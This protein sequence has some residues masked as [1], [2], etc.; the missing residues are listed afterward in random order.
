MSA[1]KS[2]FFSKGGAKKS[3]PYF[4]AFLGILL[5]A[6]FY[7]NTLGNPFIWD[8]EGL[9][10]N[11][12][13][14][15]SGA[16]LSSVFLRDLYEQS[17]AGS[18]FYRP[19]Q[20]LSFMA[21][22][23]LWG[24]DP[25]GYHV[26]NILLQAAVSFLVFLLLLRLTG[27]WKIAYPAA[28]LFAVSPLH[29]EVVAYIA[30]RADMLMAVFA[31][32]SLLLFMRAEDAQGGWPRFA[33][34]AAS[35]VLFLCALLS[36]E[37]AAVLPLV[38]TGWVVYFHRERLR[39]RWYFTLA[40]FPYFVVASLYG[41][42]R[43]TALR[44]STLWLPELTKY[45]FWLRFMVLPR[46]IGEY[47]AMLLVPMGLHMSRTVTRPVTL[48]GMGVCLGA[49]ALLVVAVICA[50][51]YYRN[52][53]VGVFLGFWAAVFFLPQSGLFPINAFVAEHFIYLP[54]VSFY[55]LLAYLLFRSLGARAYYLVVA[56]LVLGYGLLTMSR[57]YEWKD[58][59][60]FYEG[61][62][63]H[64]P[65]SFLA[66]NN[67]GVAYVKLGRYDEAVERFQEA[68]ALKPGRVEANSNLADV[69]FRMGDYEK[70]LEY[71]R[72]VEKIVPAHKAA[73]IQNNIGIVYQ[74]Y[75]QT[76][77]ALERFQLALRLD[78]GLSYVH[79]NIAKIL[80]A[81]GRVEKAVDEIIRSFPE[82]D[83]LPASS[84]GYR[85]IIRT[86]LEEQRD[87]ACPGS[88]YNNL[89]AA[90]A[91]AGYAHWAYQSFLRALELRP[92][93]ADAFFNIGLLRARQGEVIAARRALRK[94]LDLS[95]EHT[96]AAR[97]M[98]TVR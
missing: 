76:E 85:P 77:K 67:L 3:L 88:F 50:L 65:A 31:L 98:D 61:I 27:D 18:N 23:R 22:H 69:H 60:L 96:R 42:L 92:D 51:V 55:A 46:V 94:A 16:S 73:E 63:R 64:S 25:R 2:C 17:L 44:F 45:P 56:M 57:N 70:S 47:I 58:P 35:L 53:R 13:A 90:L 12:P 75:G 97:L 54:S 11:N 62:I 80:F 49:A 71:Y 82:I 38:I 26:T 19:L 86:L 7:A 24:L 91:E 1:V 28:L 32:G 79:F 66:Q 74:A 15:R 40:V 20:T 83:S 87:A 52:R 41:I 14:V 89:G 9:I 33:M 36:K 34:R 37:L 59:V 78:P 48:L 6:V 30:G 5:L 72:T 21:D 81:D 84:A 95:P 39:R 43:Y 8:D 68:L 4:F 93:Y 10:V 29:T